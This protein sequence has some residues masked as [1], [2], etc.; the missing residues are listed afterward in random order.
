MVVIPVQSV[1]DQ[2][3]EADSYSL[4]WGET[5]N[6]W[7]LGWNAQGPFVETGD[8]LGKRQGQGTLSDGQWHHLLVTTQGMV[9]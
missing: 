9:I 6:L 2:D 7:D 4:G 3:F 8:G 5:G 1:L